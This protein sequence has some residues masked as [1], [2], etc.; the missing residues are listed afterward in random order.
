M[1]VRCSPDPAALCPFCCIGQMLFWR[2][3]GQ[4]GGTAAQRI[5]FHSMWFPRITH[6]CI[7]RKERWKISKTRPITIQLY[8][9]PRQRYVS[10][11]FS[12]SFSS[13]QLRKVRT[14]LNPNL[15]A[16]SLSWISVFFAFMAELA[17]L[18]N[19]GHMHA[20]FLDRSHCCCLESTKK[21]EQLNI[22]PLMFWPTANQKTDIM[23]QSSFQSFTEIYRLPTLTWQGCWWL[24][25]SYSLCVYSREMS[26]LCQPLA[27]AGY[28][29]FS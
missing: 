26:V 22:L 2:A 12:P 21:R 1:H 3:S 7:T 17:F 25:T 9:L 5:S 15:M 24:I 20:L 23:D 10:S 16:T 4:S 27:S 28:Y 19:A 29:I 8:L 13:C 6:N 18:V 14:T 11:S